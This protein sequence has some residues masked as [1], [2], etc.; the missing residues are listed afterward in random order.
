MAGKHA[1]L[2]ELIVLIAAL[3]SAG[4]A[5]APPTWIP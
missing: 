1:L 2:N 4:V 5:I 3:S